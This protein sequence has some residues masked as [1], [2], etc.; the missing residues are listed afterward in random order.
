MKKGWF[1]L[2]CVLQYGLEIDFREDGEHDQLITIVDKNY[3]QNSS[4]DDDET[5]YLL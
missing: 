2:I 4:S 5:D 1:L 3:I